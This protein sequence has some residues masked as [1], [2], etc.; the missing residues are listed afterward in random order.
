VAR[1]D[2]AGQQQGAQAQGH[3]L[4]FLDASG[5]YPLPS[6]VRTDAPVG[7]TPSLRAWWTRAHLSAISAMSLEGTR[8]F[9]AQDRAINS[10]DVV[11]F[12][13]HVLREVSGRMIII[14][15]GAPMPRSQVIQ[16]FLANGAA[17]RL[18]LERLPA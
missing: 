3:T 15:D 17:Q 1:Q 4:F 18:H 5:F 14:W 2:L 6:V 13:Q 7:Q 9:H 10:A 12:R 16:A 8:S 11:A